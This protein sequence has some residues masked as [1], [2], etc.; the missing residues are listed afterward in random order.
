MPV[1]VV[2]GAS[3]DRNKFG[4]KAR[5]V[6][7][8][9]G[10]DVRPVHP[11]ATEIEGVPAV[12]SLDQLDPGVDRVTMYVPPAVGLTMLEAIVELAPEEFWV[13]PGAESPELIQQAQEMGL[14]P[15]IGCAILDIGESPATP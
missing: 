10:W 5:R 6:Y 4:N 2:V 15:I 13:N 12:A 1:V 9:Q 8:R 14:E 3:S 7:M 11:S